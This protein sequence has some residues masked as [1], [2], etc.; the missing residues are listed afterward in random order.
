MRL[1]PNTSVLNRIGHSHHWS[2]KCQAPNLNFGLGADKAKM[3]YIL[4]ST[5]NTLSQGPTVCGDAQSDPTIMTVCNA[6]LTHQLGHTFQE[7]VSILAP[8]TILDKLEGLG[9]RVVGVTGAGQTCIWTLHK[10]T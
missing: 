5:E 10:E 4:I 8:R 1:L 3:V 6:E 7:Y 2:F 9:F